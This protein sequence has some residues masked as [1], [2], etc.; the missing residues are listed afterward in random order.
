MQIVII[1]MVEDAT[2]FCRDLF[3]HSAP[4]SRV[5]LTIGNRCEKAMSWEGYRGFH[6]KFRYTP[7]LTGVFSGERMLRWMHTQFCPEHGCLQGWM[8]VRSKANSAGAEVCP[9]GGCRVVAGCL[10]RASGCEPAPC[11]LNPRPAAARIEGAIGIAHR[12]GRRMEAGLSWRF[13]RV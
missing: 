13:C 5:F 9:E 2:R 11:T 3:A 8:R 12:C 10:E 6:G 7:Q 4:F 1:L